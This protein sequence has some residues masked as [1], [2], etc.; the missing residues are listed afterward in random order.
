LSLFRQAVRTA[1]AMAPSSRLAEEWHKLFSEA[2]RPNAAA[3]G[4]DSGL[5]TER[6]YS[7]MRCFFRG[8][9]PACRSAFFRAGLE[10]VSAGGRFLGGAGEFVME[11]Y[12]F[13]PPRDPACW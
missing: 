3:L 7:A 4:P 11:W 6:P 1:A 8:P 2:P 13:G 9:T 5:S 10:R 12:L